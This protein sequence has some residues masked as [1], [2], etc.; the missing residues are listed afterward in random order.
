MN[1]PVLSEIEKLPESSGIFALLNDEAN[2]LFVGAAE[3]LKREVRKTLT[4]VSL[5][6][7][8]ARIESV[9]SPK[10]DLIELYN[11]TL[12]RKNPL[13]NLSVNKQNSF[14]Y[15]KI[16]RE[17]FPRLLATRRVE[18]DEAEYFGAFLPATSVRFLLGFLI[19]KF[20]L[21][22]CNIEIDGE[23]PVPCPQ[24]YRKKCVAPCI[25]DLC[26]RQ[27]YLYNVNLVRLF[28]QNRRDELNDELLEKI[29]KN[30]AELDFETA[31]FRRD[32]RQ[33]INDF[34]N[35]KERNFRLDEATDTFEIERADANF[36][37][38]QVT[39]QRR[40]TLGR[41][42]FFYE[43]KID[44][45]RKEVLAQVLWQLYRLR[46]PKEIFVPV[47]FENRKLLEKLL[48]ERAERSVKIIVLKN[49]KNKITAK[50]ALR[51]TEFEYEFENVKPPASLR[52]IQNELK[53]HFS[54]P[55]R[56]QR[57]EAFDVAHI[58]GTDFVGAKSV[59]DSGKFLAEEYEFWFSDE[60]SEIAALAETVMRRFEKNRTPPDLIL[61]DGGK[62]QLKA[63]LKSIG[64]LKGQ[65]FSIIS[66]VKPPLKHNEISHF[67]TESG[68][69]VQFKN[70]SGAFN[71]LLKLRDEAHDLA[72]YIHR[73]KRESA[74][75]YEVFQAL[76]FL[77]EK[78]RYSLVRRFGSLNALKNTSET[79]LV[80]FA[81]EEKGKSVYRKLKKVNKSGEPFIVPIRYDAPNGESADLSPLNDFNKKTLIV[82]K[83]ASFFL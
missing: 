13:Y 40:K 15:L 80:E 12:D 68:N 38:R 67:L 70:N 59:W 69:T 49:E 3:N 16:T 8:T 64:K 36:L 60:K 53:K 19:D 72:N 75:F 20:G 35:D 65:N 63:V 25:E 73:A 29:E 79:E 23:F 33:S 56:L 4:N 32:L 51:R 76:S 71:L 46:T 52:D 18:R 17:T 27:S 43:N 1:S 42:T 21:R 28:L 48:S 66:A 34:W 82:N 9:E 7:E 45:S 10:N 14:P 81:G 24:Y 11:Q 30:S 39:L 41:Q 57:I 61:I 2:S 47:D 22:G 37:I 58:S 83:L 78:E 62:S 55:R 31:A 5:K 44:S 74:H 6:K 77:P 26:D 50:R 54:L